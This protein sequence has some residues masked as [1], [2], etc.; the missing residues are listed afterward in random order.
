MHAVKWVLPY[1]T[2]Y[3]LRL[4]MAFALDI[5]VA[6]MYLIYPYMI[7]RIVRDVIYGEMHER[8]F[9]YLALNVG[10][11]LFRTCMRY[12]SVISF[13]SIS[14]RVVY[15]LRQDIYGKLHSL[16]HNFF[17]TNR[18][19]DIMARMTGDLDAI[20]AYISHDIYIVPENILFFLTSIVIMFSL[21]WQL[22]LCMLSVAPVIF[23][24]AYKQ[25]V[26]IKP[27]YGNIREQFSHLNSVC[28]E[29]IGGNRVIKAFA[30]EGYEIQKFSE[31]SQ[32][33]YQS[34]VDTNKVYIKYHPILNT[35]AGV[36]PFFLV[37]VGSILVIYGHMEVWQMVAFSGYLWMVT[38]PMSL[39]G[40]YVNT[41]Q[42][43]LTSLDKVFGMMRKPIYIESP[44][45]AVGKE[46]LEGA[47]EFLNVS[48]GYDRNDPRS[49]VLKDVSFRVERGWTLGIVGA[50]G[51]GKTT[52]A[53]LL[54]R[55]YD[56]F[57]G[58]VLVDGV[59]VREYDLQSLR[60]N[61][62]AAM[63]DVFLFSDTIEGNIAYGVPEAPMKTLT[64]AAKVADADG[65]ISR[66]P[67]GYDTIV[68]ERGVGLSGGQKQR[69][70]LA[71]ALA[72]D[73][74]IL[75]LDDTTSAVDM[76]TERRIQAALKDVVR[77]SNRIT[78][79]IAH[80]LSSVKAANLILVLDNGAVTERGTHDE[81]MA[82]GG[83]YA[84]QYT[85]QLGLNPF[86]GRVGEPHGA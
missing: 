14:Q 77:D 15:N 73:P 75:I 27:K 35:A 76:D 50:T 58:E 53:N 21:S 24:T 49:L 48:F 1:V 60:G 81:L 13:E 56:V 61:I 84:R 57:S 40:S 46:K 38:Q 33:Y 10:I 11:V 30:K 25:S 8:L 45:N 2:R 37:L 43:F 4:V 29:N 82:I 9:F 72:T 55:F 26:A 85:E 18:V 22:A 39:F 59:D 54:C 79:I 70:S 32:A 66:M 44:E 7:G 83:Y 20:R 19:G 69:I 17:D 67:D 68:G 86:S 74:S 63:Q 28:A 80:R 64:D 47:V 6:L 52:V 41:A 71:R 34:H 36:M 5:A 31:A 16:D 42:N 12:I 65:F 23:V 78:I 3:K 62:S 51:S